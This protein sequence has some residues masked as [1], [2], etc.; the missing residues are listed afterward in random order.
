MLIN[1]SGKVKKHFHFPKQNQPNRRSLGGQTHGSCHLHN[2]D[3]SFA[4][5]LVTVLSAYSVLTSWYMMCLQNG[6]FFMCF[7]IN[8]LES[9]WKTD[10]RRKI[11]SSFFLPFP[12]LLSSLPP[13]SIP[14][15]LLLTLPAHF[16][17]EFS[18]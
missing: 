7:T 9:Y 13:S 1:Y 8:E 15:S 17:P 18:L 4:F 11:S 3:D 2:S 5:L 12:L 10:I 6:G 16:V 14:S